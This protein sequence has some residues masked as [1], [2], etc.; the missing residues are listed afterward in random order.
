[1]KIFN[2]PS[3]AKATEGRQF[4]IFNPRQG[5]YPAPLFLDKNGS[6]SK[7][8]APIKDI[9]Q[10]QLVK[11]GAGFTLIELLVVIGISAILAG[12]GLAFTL[13]FYRSYA[14]NSERDLVVGLMQKARAR[15]MSNLNQQ[16]YG[17]CITNSNY[18]LFAGAFNCEPGNSANEV[19]PANPSISNTNFAVIFQQ[20]RGNPTFYNINGSVSATSTLTLLKYG[21]AGPATVSV[22][23]EGQI[24][25]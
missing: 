11:S 15:S 12:L 21:T 23:P 7:I 14:F 19:Y 5:I 16:S 22:N 24:Q 8:V 17:V 18:I 4:S 2:F 9:L 10:T 3:F 13:D 20:L 1:M 6:D 25:W